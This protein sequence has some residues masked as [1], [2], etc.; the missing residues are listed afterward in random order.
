MG[1][2]SAEAVLVLLVLWNWSLV[3]A[4]HLTVMILD[5]CMQILI[6]IVHQ[7]VSQK[8]KMLKEGVLWLR[9]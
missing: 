6:L 9:Q 2:V 3:F 8:Q 7:V 5:L 4:A 1:V